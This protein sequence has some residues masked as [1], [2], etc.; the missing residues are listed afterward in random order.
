MQHCSQLQCLVFQSRV[1]NNPASED[2]SISQRDYP[3]AGW[4]SLSS[5]PF[6]SPMKSPRIPRWDQGRA[7]P[8]P[9]KQTHQTLPKAMSSTADECCSQSLAASLLP[10]PPP[11]HAELSGPA[12]WGASGSAPSAHLSAGKGQVCCPTAL[13]VL[14]AVPCTAGPGRWAHGL[15][16]AVP[17][18]DLLT[19]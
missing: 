8:F 10:A 3:T 7:L 4:I 6:K 16:T 17:C 12:A 1:L 14:L 18:S 19:C 9:G 2:S 11:P 13:L 15:P 5:R